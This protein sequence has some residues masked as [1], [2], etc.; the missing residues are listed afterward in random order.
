MKKLFVVV[1]TVVMLFSIS[2]NT[3]AVSCPKS[4]EVNISAPVKV[5]SGE[6][7]TL[8]AVTLK[9]G[10]DYR[11]QWIGATKVS[12]VLTEDGYYISTAQF[13]AKE[14]ASVQYNIIMEAGNGKCF[15][16][17]AQ[18]T[19]EVDNPVS[20]VG[21]LVKNVTPVPSITGFYTGDIYVIFSDGTMTL[22]GTTYFAMGENETSKNLD[23]VVMVD[24]VQYEFV[25]EV[26]I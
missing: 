24:G 8:T 10:S 25:V 14:A 12:T 20:V 6:I 4:V 7:V 18:T 26:T 15:E 19:V 16:G 9:R 1:L 23:V 22:S 11:D 13:T 21:A 2:L 5:Q 17:Q 3:L